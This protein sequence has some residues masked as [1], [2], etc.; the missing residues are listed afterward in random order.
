MKELSAIVTPTWNNEDYTIRCFDSISKNTQNYILIWIDNGS[1]HESR[2]KVK[3]FLDIRNIPY[4]SIFNQENLGF[5]KATN[6]GI[7]KAL[8]LKAGYII[9]ENNDTEVYGKWLERMIE[10]AK[11][12]RKIGLVGPITSP[13]TTLQS[14]INIEKVY[15]KEDF[16]DLPKY[17]D[18]PE[19]YSKKI[20]LLYNG[21]QIESKTELAFF[22][23]LIK[24][25]VIK[26]IGLL[27][28]EFGVGFGDDNDY[29][30]RAMK[31]GWKLFIAKDV[32][33]FHNHRTTFK[34]IYSE[35]EIEEM[36][37]KNSKIY[38]E[39]HSDFSINKKSEAEEESRK[40][41]SEYFGL[42]I[43]GFNELRYKG[44]RVLI[45]SIKRHLKK[46]IDGKK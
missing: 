43:L 8:E 6:Q 46:R 10:V 11:S 36:L 35:N 21:Q 45:S 23:T 40:I 28:E 15:S 30:I 19:E 1:E 9:L 13:C 41:F 38:S 33:V 27:S 32:F 22:S 16:P 18:D 44:A 17:N 7:R 42:I 26:D 20:S 37:N 31:A 2:K 29:C 39:K 34:T 12:N 4:I 3:D 24:S 14:I 25:S 5:V